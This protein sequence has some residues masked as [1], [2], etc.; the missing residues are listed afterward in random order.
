MKKLLI[1]LCLFTFVLP[2][3][4][5]NNYNNEGFKYYDD[6]GTQAYAQKLE[7]EY[8]AKVDK[9]EVECCGPNYNHYVR[10]PIFKYIE[11]HP[12]DYSKTVD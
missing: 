11:E 12:I 3:F 4:S 2:S 6:K 5:E 9:G 8:H 10:H 7:K 1:I